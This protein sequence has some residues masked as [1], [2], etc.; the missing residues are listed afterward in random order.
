MLPLS[1][2]A[3]SYDVHTYI[4]FNQGHNSLD[5]VVVYVYCI[6]FYDVVVVTLLLFSPECNDYPIL[7]DNTLSTNG[8]IV[9][10]RYSS[11]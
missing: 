1:R 8:D 9:F 2:A 11:K 6:I 4:E 7:F 3:H 10:Q 5:I